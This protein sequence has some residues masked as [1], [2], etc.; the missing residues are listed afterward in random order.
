MGG[1]KFIGPNYTFENISN[2][3]NT[4]NCRCLGYT[5]T[6]SHQVENYLLQD[7]QLDIENLPDDELAEKLQSYHL[8]ENLHYTVKLNVHSFTPAKKPLLKK[9]TADIAFDDVH[10]QSIFKIDG[11]E[12]I[13]YNGDVS[14]HGTKYKLIR[15]I[16][17][18]WHR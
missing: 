15:G 12:E 14:S 18:P 2:M 8:G 9:A 11:A 13:A 4:S 17:H 10:V 7:T 16:K 5:G 1:F 3:S 6:I